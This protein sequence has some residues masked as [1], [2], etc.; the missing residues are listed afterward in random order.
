[1]AETAQDST[2]ASSFLPDRLQKQETLSFANLARVSTQGQMSAWDEIIH[3][4]RR[5]TG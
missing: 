3:C 5:L 2:E 1:M 4:L